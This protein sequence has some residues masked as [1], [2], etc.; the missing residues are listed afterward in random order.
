MS[1]VLGGKR[2]VGGLSWEEKWPRRDGLEEMVLEKWPRKNS[3]GEM[4]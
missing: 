1:I 2:V 3:L 4:A